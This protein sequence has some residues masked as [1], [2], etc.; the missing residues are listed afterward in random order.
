MLQFASPSGEIGNPINSQGSAP[1]ENHNVEK[2]GQHAL[3]TG[4][5][6]RV[7]AIE[8]D[9]DENTGWDNEDSNPF[10]YDQ[11]VDSNSNNWGKQTMISKKFII[12][13]KN[14]ENFEQ[15]PALFSP[16]STQIAAPISTFGSYP[17]SF[18]NSGSKAQGS[19]KLSHKPKTIG[20]SFT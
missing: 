7:Q 4:N 11:Q 1:V 19:M 20:N 2:P 3:S 8:A 17:S 18:G 5:P 10:D 9:D 6:S 16:P 13:K 12:N 14:V 15:P